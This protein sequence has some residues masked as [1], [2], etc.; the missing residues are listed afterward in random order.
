MPPSACRRTSRASRPWV[1]RAASAL[2]QDSISQPAQPSAVAR[3][4]A[5][6]RYEAI[7]LT[8]V[9]RAVAEL[10][11]GSTVAVT[12]SPRHGLERTLAVS[13]TLARA[14]FR[15]VP[16]LAAHMVLGRGHLETIA[17]RLRAAH[18][19]EV[20]VVGGDAPATPAS[21]RDAGD[22]LE[23][24]VE[25]P[26]SPRRLGVAGHPE[27]TSEGR[28][29]TTRRGSASQGGARRL[30]GDADVL[31]RWHAARLDPAPAR[32]RRRPSGHRR[33]AGT[34]ER[35]KLVELAWRTGVGVSLR[36]IA[37]QGRGLSTLARH[38]RHDPTAL[39]TEIA[40]H[41]DDPGLAMAGTCSPST[42]SPRLER[43]SP[44]RRAAREGGASAPEFRGLFLALRRPL[45]LSE[46]RV[47]RDGDPSL[48]SGV[49]EG[50]EGGLPLAAHTC[51]CATRGPERLTVARV[52]TLTN[53][54]L[55]LFRRGSGCTQV[56][57][58]ASES[59]LGIAPTREAT[60]RTASRQRLLWAVTG[61]LKGLE[62]C[63]NGVIRG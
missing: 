57:G 45:V 1:A 33:P 49:Q 54:P 25:L 7:P 9:E 19:D 8:G 48:N 62:G 11:P 47:R 40:A 38:R 56:A 30:R 18:I 50:E 2:K 42:A 32:D 3:L 20:F 53:T 63:P 41:L 16:H 23:A 34:V 4:L 27:G 21:Y 51:N 59:H 29:P 26:L 13:E 35:R 15:V 61:F 28:R 43:G 24:L 14:G 5:V 12:A 58:Q 55:P 60:Q 22:L 10:A 52:A 6:P 39:A 46:A 31:R 37:G 36:Y 44:R 17:G